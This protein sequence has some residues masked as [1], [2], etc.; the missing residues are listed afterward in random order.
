[1]RGQY[2]RIFIYPEKS[3]WPE[4]G[5][6]GKQLPASTNWLFISYSSL[7][8]LSH[9]AEPDRM[10]WKAAKSHGHERGKAAGRG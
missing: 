1:V 6:Y 9:G 4:D 8:G 2:L 10:V 3:P 5:D 7:I